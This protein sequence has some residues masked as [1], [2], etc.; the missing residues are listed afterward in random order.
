MKILQL[1]PYFYPA[2]S[3]G[4]SAT[5]VYNLSGEL[6]KRGHNVTVYTTDVNHSMPE[7]KMLVNKR[8]RIGGFDVYYFRNISNNLAFRNHIFSPPYFFTEIIRHITD[9]DI[10]H[11]HEI[12]TPMHLWAAFLA[13]KQGIPYILTGHGT[14]MLGEKDG[15]MGRKK[16]FYSFGGKKLLLG[17]SRI[18]ALTEKEKRSYLKLGVEEKN[19]RVIPNGI[20]PELFHKLPKKE[21]FRNKMRLAKDDCVILYLGRLHAKKGIELLIK[22]LKLLKNEHLSVKL[23]I[24]GPVEQEDYLKRLKTII[25]KES[26]SQ[27]VIF[28]GNLTGKE[29]MGAYS[30]ADIFALTSYSEGLPVSVLEAAVC[31]LPLLLSEN[32]GVPMIE[33]YNAGV[34]VKND[35]DSI[36]KGLE[37]ILKKD[38][39]RRYYGDNAKKMAQKE[40]SISR[41]A[42]MTEKVYKEF[43]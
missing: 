8:V 16:L 31:G 22:S 18:V 4:G 24:A 36:E 21:V 33:K 28:T 9:F 23:V 2:L 26:L 20:N 15:N 19:I 39:F 13:R 17:A 32:S 11:M 35:L 30:S 3:V 7:K 34:L 29:K 14:A 12:Y 42:F 10:V 41:T 27:N 5:A 1:V 6:V 40:Y 43:V 25:E 38:N 37:R